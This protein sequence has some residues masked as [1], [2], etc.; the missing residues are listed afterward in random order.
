MRVIE[1]RTTLD[2]LFAYRARLVADAPVHQPGADYSYR[3]KEAFARAKT[4]H[5]RC[6]RCQHKCLRKNRHCHDCAALL[7]RGTSEYHVSFSGRRV[8]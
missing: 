8:G 3:T 4:E 6:A 5:G 7:A 2:A 1:A